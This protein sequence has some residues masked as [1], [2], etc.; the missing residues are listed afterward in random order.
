M[1]DG[2]TLALIPPRSSKAIPPTVAPSTRTRSTAS[3]MQSFF[4]FSS[5]RRDLPGALRPSWGPSGMLMVLHLAL[6]SAGLVADLVGH[7]AGRVLVRARVPIA[8]NAFAHLHHREHAS[9]LD[10]T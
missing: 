7:R 3:A 10:G 6:R 9:H 5:C 1:P 8:G 2:S 4:T